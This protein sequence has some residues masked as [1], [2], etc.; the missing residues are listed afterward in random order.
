MT[1]ELKDQFV[2]S[3]HW[4]DLEL[5]RLAEDVLKNGVTIHQHE[6]LGPVM[7]W[8]RWYSCKT[9]TDGEVETGNVVRLVNRCISLAAERK[10]PLFHVKMHDAAEVVGFATKE[11]GEF[12]ISLPKYVFQPVRNRLLRMTNAKFH[13]GE[14]FER[15]F[16]DVKIHMF[17]RHHEVRVRAEKSTIAPVTIS[18]FY[19]QYTPVAPLETSGARPSRLSKLRKEQNANVPTP[20]TE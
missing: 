4:G 11:K 6:Q 1:S 5:V 17:G 2:S 19:V 14:N 3:S 10:L 9:E 16:G 15:Y 13:K 8:M 20:P 7:R 12:V 18:L